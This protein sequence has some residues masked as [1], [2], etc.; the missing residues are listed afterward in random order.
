MLLILGLGIGIILNLALHQFAYGLPP[1]SCVTSPYFP[2]VCATWGWGATIVLVLGAFA[3]VIGAAM[4]SI[5]LQLSPAPLRLFDT[6][7][8]F[9]PDPAEP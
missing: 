5:G 3:S 1:P 7:G 9:P 4:I 2:P 8:K 6:E